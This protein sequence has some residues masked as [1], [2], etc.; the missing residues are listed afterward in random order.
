[1]KK[2]GPEQRPGRRLRIIKALISSKRYNYSKKVQISIEEGDFELEDIEHCILGAE[3]IEKV[4]LDELGTAIDG[5]KYTI[6]GEDIEGMSFYTCG[7]LIRSSNS[8]M[9]Y[10]FMTAHAP[11]QEY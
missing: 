10:F 9:L 11:D 1:M 5:C 6:L 8:Q 7:K 4:E 2:K 3:L